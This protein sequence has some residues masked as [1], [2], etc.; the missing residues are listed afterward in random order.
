[1][2]INVN[3]DTDTQFANSL[4]Q[5]CLKYLASHPDGELSHKQSFWDKPV[6][7]EAITELNHLHTSEYHQSTPE[8]TLMTGCLLCQ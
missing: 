8:S 2:V 4:E 7:A 1:M 5:R 3:I 6:I